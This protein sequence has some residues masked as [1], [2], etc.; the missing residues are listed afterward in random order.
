[1]SVNF[2]EEEIIC[3]KDLHILAKSA[4]QKKTEKDN[5]Q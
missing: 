1:M 2:L 4:A 3:M 5:I